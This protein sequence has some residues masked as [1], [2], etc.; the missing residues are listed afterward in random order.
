MASRW[1]ATLLLACA[2]ATTAL[3][4][5][6]TPAHRLGTT[7]FE[8]F[9]PQGNFGGSGGVTLTSVETAL[10]VALTSLWSEDETCVVEFLRH[11]G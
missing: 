3:Q 6:P 7:A 9:S 8:R 5:P 1:T 4:A 11:F 10:P 2:M